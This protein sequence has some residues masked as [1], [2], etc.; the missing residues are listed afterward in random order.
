M[1]HYQIEPRSYSKCKAVFNP[2]KITKVKIVNHP[3][4]ISNKIKK[5]FPEYVKSSAVTKQSD[6]KLLEYE[7]ITKMKSKINTILY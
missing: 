7:R 5:K 6:K 1:N 3:A 2:S 4:D